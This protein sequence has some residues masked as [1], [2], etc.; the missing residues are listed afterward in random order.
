M[1]TL[2]ELKAAESSFRQLLRENDL[3]RPDE[4]EYRE[5]SIACFWF[6][7]SSCVVIDVDEAPDEEAL[8]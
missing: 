2:E 4:V 8:G 1:A 3:P 5:T 7:T 6:E